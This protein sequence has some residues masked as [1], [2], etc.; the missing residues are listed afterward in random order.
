LW[1]QIVQHLCAGEDRPESNQSGADG[2]ETDTHG[3]AEAMRQ[4]TLTVA[5][6]EMELARL[7]T[8]LEHQKS[9]RPIFGPLLCQNRRERQH[10]NNL[11]RILAEAGIDYPMLTDTYSKDGNSSIA[12]LLTSKL[13]EAKPKE[14]EELHELLVG[15]FNPD[16][17][18]KC[19]TTEM[20][21]EQTEMNKE[22]KSGVGDASGSS[23]PDTASS[24]PVKARSSS[25]ETTNTNTAYPQKHSVSAGSVVT[26]SL[27]PTAS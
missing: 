26:S 9:L 24:S 14:V 19:E 6:E 7:K 4:Y 18:S 1:L 16:S 12:Q 21:K 3:L 10:A 27:E 8:V 15:H 20:N 5:K 11:R 17:E 23:T 25:G 2:R 13:T 22:S